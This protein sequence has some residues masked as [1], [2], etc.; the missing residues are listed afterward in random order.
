M[1]PK[2]AWQGSTAAGDPLSLCPQQTVTRWGRALPCKA[3]RGFRNSFLVRVF[4]G[5]GRTP[6]WSCLPCQGPG[7]AAGPSDPLGSLGGGRSFSLVLV[8]ATV[9]HVKTSRFL[10][11]SLAGAIADWR[12]HLCL[13]PARSSASCRS[14]SRERLR[15]WVTADI[16][17]EDKSCKLNFCLA[18][19]SC[20]SPVSWGFVDERGRRFLVII[21]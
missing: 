18:G 10:P 2:H 6:F 5:G 14:P 15:E 7:R 3:G 17:M 8:F 13:S 21:S 9:L 19:G 20:R 16:R 4:P 11:Q 12:C 1:R